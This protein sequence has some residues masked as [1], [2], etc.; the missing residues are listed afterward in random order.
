MEDEVGDAAGTE[1]CRKAGDPELRRDEA[2]KREPD[3][4]EDRD[5]EDVVA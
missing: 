1:G 2:K 5:P 3:Q 4:G